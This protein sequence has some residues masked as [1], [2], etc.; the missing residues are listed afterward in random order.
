[1]AEE[2]TPKTEVSKP[3][4]KPALTPKASTTPK[5]VAKPVAKP[6]VTPANNPTGKPPVR[7]A[8][9]PTN[10][11][12]FERPKRKPLRWGLCHIFSSFNN[13]IIH[14]TDITG[15]ESIARTSGGQVVKADRME[16]SPTAAMI[17]AKRAAEVAMERGITGIHVK[18]RAPGGHNGPSS[19]GPGAQAA[20]RA[21]SRMGLRIGVIQDVTPV[22]HDGCRKKGGRRGRRV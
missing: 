9:N 3:A 5:P 18:I 7:P 2:T 6:A 21:L 12:R 1:M 16:S 10:K 15:T 14:I 17:A 11:P 20:V 13:T 4:S 8:G 19:P 22:P